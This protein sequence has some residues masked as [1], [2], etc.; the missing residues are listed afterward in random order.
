MARELP[1]VMQTQPTDDACGA[2]APRA[3]FDHFTI[4]VAI[5]TCDPFQRAHGPAYRLARI[6]ELIRLQP[7]V[8]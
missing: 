7:E 1:R 8:A 5:L 3:I 6:A 2:A 4:R